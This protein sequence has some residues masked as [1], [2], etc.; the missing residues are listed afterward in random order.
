[1]IERISFA[2]DKIEEVK[3]NGG[4]TLDISQCGLQEFP[5]EVLELKHLETLI[6]G[7]FY[8]RYEHDYLGY[9][10]FYNE[11]SEIPKEIIELE[12][13]KT[14]DLTLSPNIKLPEEF[15]KLNKLEKL[16]LR[17]CGLNEIPEC[18]FELG[19]LKILMLDSIEDEK[20]L[21]FHKGYSYE[22]FRENYY[23][24]DT[25][26][27]FQEL[28]Y[29]W[30]NGDRFKNRIS[31]ISPKL[32]QLRNLEYLSLNNNE[33]NEYPEFIDF[34]P[35]IKEVSILDNHLTFHPINEKRKFDLKYN[36]KPIEKKGK[37]FEEKVFEEFEKLIESKVDLS[38]KKSL[39]NSKFF[40]LKENYID[41][42]RIVYPVIEQ[43]VNE[44]I[45]GNGENPKDRKKFKGLFD[46]LNFLIELEVI[47][48]ELFDSIQVNLP[49]NGILHGSL[50]IQNMNLLYP[51]SLASFIFVSELMRRIE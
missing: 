29:H 33:L 28:L 44:L 13:L 2:K 9:S 7:G 49:R 50:K 23:H 46:K 30:G 10:G 17:A 16:I 27:H 40:F 11:I 3:L 5:K 48:R 37:H 45:S 43:I 36:L 24:L 15:G 32:L 47:S 31:D 4:H 14:I 41:S 34:L 35:N 38:I 39:E 25:D 12:N 22:D 26:D 51:T 6:L 18:I 19:S 20:R 8:Q 21:A 42:L 1:M